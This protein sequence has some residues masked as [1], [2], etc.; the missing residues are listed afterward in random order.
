MC[1][2]EPEGKKDKRHSHAHACLIFDD[3]A[4]YRKVAFDHILE[5]IRSNEKCIM[6]IDSYT[7]AMI[8]EDFKRHGLCVDDYLE[9]GILTIV[10][11]QTSYAGE[12]E[13]EPEKTIEIWQGGDAEGDCA[14]LRGIASRRRGGL[15]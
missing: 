8:A 3:L 1:D 7:P 13:F 6:A 5:G 14:R 4:C 9:R 10:D 2:T 11:V 12:Q 15:F